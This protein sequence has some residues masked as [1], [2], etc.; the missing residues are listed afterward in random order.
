MKNILYISFYFEPD[1]CAGSFR[2]TPLAY[3]LSKQN[4]ISVDV[5]TTMPNR[6]HN[7]K[8]NVAEKECRTEIKINRFDIPP[9]KSS[10][11]DQ[12]I[13][14][15]VFYCKVM[16]Y[17]KNRK[18]DLVFASTSRFF[19]GYL[20]YRISLKKNIPLYL[21][22]RDLFFDTI[23]NIYKGKIISFL[24]NKIRRLEPKV[25]KRASHINLISPAFHEYIC[26]FKSNNLTSFT[27][28][29]DEEFLVELKKKKNN[30]IIPVN[31]K[32]RKIVYAG[33]VGEGQGLHK[34][35]P[36]VSEATL[37]RFEFD[38]YGGGGAMNKLVDAVNAQ[39][40]KNINIFDPVKRCDLLDIY[41]GADILFLHLNDNE[42]FEKIIPS[43]IFELSCFNK[44]IMAG[45]SGYAANF[46]SSEIPDTYIFEPCNGDEMVSLMSKIKYSV[47]TR[48]TFINNYK[49]NVID[50]KL[51]R[52]IMNYL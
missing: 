3:E 1:L 17:T 22:V 9:H 38:I 11:V 32:V 25:F 12:I 42:A 46:L 44:P 27:H 2:N 49:R 19:S 29:I 18:Y 6:Y 52:S 16:K 7:Y 5:V 39:N 28:G 26:R 36:A 14:F 23:K 35:L 41:L 47:P 10:I 40:L 24:I 37:G 48:D 4:N 31:R 15:F 45:V 20:A 30:L 34:I 51:V 13:S 21:D 33:N 8:T 43:K 50:E